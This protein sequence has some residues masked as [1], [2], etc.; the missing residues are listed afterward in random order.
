[1]GG[2]SGGRYPVRAATAHATGRFGA[3]VQLAPNGAARGVVTARDGT[4]TVLWGLL[5]DPEGEIVDQILASRRPVGTA[6]FAP[7][8]PISHGETAVN[9]AALALNPQTDQP[10]ALWVGA[11]GQPLDGVPLQPRY[12]ARAG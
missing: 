1:V 12:S 7:P 11:P 5:T 8:E 10:A 2:G 9:Y 3:S 6:A 4:T